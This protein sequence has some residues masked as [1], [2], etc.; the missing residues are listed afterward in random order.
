[1]SDEKICFQSFVAVKRQIFLLKGDICFISVVP[2]LAHATALINFAVPRDSVNTG[3]SE[4]VP[5][6]ISYCW[7]ECN[8]PGR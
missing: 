5:C 8:S 3:M 7:K 2:L 6:G 1:M 4:H